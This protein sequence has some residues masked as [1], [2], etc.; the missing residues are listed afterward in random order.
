MFKMS[1]PKLN[2]SPK[3]KAAALGPLAFTDLLA[4]FIESIV[5]PTR[6]SLN[7]ANVR[8]IWTYGANGPCHRRTTDAL[9]GALKPMMIS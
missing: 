5:E 6:P 2:A 1:K 3:A 9:E 4:I 7:L 8:V